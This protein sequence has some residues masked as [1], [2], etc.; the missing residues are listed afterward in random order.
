MS[1]RF[2]SYNKKKLYPPSHKSDSPNTLRISSP[3]QTLKTVGEVDQAGM[4]TY[5]PAACTWSCVC[6]VVLTFSVAGK[7]L[8]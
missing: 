1:S 3:T 2:L 6:S 8:G 4:D 5:E 7:F